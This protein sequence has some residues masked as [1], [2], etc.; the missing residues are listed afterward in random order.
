MRLSHAIASGLFI[1]QLRGMPN[2]TWTVLGV[3]GMCHIRD[4]VEEMLPSLRCVVDTIV[5]DL[6]EAD[7][8]LLLE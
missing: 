8:I 4:C 6:R 7:E 2:P 5:D 3:V 1:S